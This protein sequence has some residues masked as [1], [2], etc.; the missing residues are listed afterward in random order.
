[1]DL[2]DL[3]RDK[4]GKGKVGCG[5]SP[6]WW[7]RENDDDDEVKMT[8]TTT[9]IITMTMTLTT[10]RQQKDNHDDSNKL[11]LSNDDNHNAMCSCS[12][13]CSLTPFSINGNT[14]YLEYMRKCWISLW[15]W[16]ISIQSLEALLS[17]T[18]WCISEISL[19]FTV[20][21]ERKRKGGREE[22]DPITEISSQE[23]KYTIYTSTIKCF[24]YESKCCVSRYDS[25]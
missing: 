7:W 12:K 15:W 13:F 23:K 6:W 21:R 25:H 3:W 17:T 10:T 1:M 5:G 22:A 24:M 2:R 9:T 16:G 19:E 18:D 8:T 14:S 11:S 4:H 20:V